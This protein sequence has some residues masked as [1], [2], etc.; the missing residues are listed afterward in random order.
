MNDNAEIRAAEFLATGE[1][2]SVLWSTPSVKKET[3]DGSGSS[4]GSD[5]SA[6]ERELTHFCVRDTL[7]RGLTEI[8]F[9]RSSHVY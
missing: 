3:V 8:F 9:F 1:A 7:A 4:D 5:F 2:C 6:Q